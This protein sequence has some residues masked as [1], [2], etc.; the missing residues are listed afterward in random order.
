M[1]SLILLYKVHFL[2][3]AISFIV[4]SYFKGGNPAIKTSTWIK[5]T[6]SE[7]Y[8]TVA[9]HGKFWSGLIYF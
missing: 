5:K 2:N 8:S 3:L 7:H 6:S 9:S 4:A 1:L